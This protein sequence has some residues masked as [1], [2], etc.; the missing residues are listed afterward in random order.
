MQLQKSQYVEDELQALTLSKFRICRRTNNILR[1]E[2]NLLNCVR[3]ACGVYGNE[4]IF[5]TCSLISHCI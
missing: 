4:N 5:I 1:N 2:Q 3:I